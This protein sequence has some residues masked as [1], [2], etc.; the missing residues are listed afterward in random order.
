VKAR[1]AFTVG[2]GDIKFKDESC[3]KFF[4]PTAQ[5]KE[6]SGLSN[7]VAFQLLSYFLASS[8]GRNID[9]PRNLAKSVTV[10]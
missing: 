5:S 2:I 6:L 8:L 7:V 3:F 10:K 4:L 9:K 1:E